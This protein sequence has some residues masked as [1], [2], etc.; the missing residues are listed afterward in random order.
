MKAKKHISLLMATLCTVFS[1]F[2]NAQD[3]IYI[4]GAEGINSIT[5]GDVYIKSD[6]KTINKN[7]DEI[8]VTNGINTSNGVNKP[9]NDV[10]DDIDIDDDSDANQE[11]TGYVTATVG[12]NVRSGPGTD[13]NTIGA[14]NYKDTVTILEETNGWYKIKYGSGVGYVSA[15]YVAIK[16]NDS[17][18]SN[19][20]ST[21]GRIKKIVIDPGHG[22]SDPGAIGPT[23]LKEK[24][25][26][27]SVSLKLKN[28]LESRGV[29]VVMTRT[30]DVYLTLQERTQISNNSGAD[31]FL[32]VHTNSFSNPTSNGTETYSYNSTGMGAEVAKS[33]QNELIKAIGLT[34]RGFKTDNFY[35]IKYN[36]IPSALVE[37]A[38]ISNPNEETLLASDAFKNKCVEAIATAIL[39]Y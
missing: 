9:D 7:I 23:G 2:A 19:L 29:S 6:D 11:K 33:I 1:L 38:F 17:G 37:L 4:K 34:N 5:S 35:V 24:D 15:A 36:N 18:N 25:V 14:L 31:Y 8:T 28:L 20:P 22:G 30:T 3:T 27:L 26:V 13:Y 12:L 16:N 10:D 21:T 32:S 39:N